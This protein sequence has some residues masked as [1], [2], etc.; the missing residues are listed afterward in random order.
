M[1]VWCQSHHSRLP[2]KL[3]RTTSGSQFVSPPVAQSSL[4]SRNKEP[5][6][7]GRSPLSTGVVV[8]DTSRRSLVRLPFRQNIALLLFVMTVFHQVKSRPFGVGFLKA[9]GG[10]A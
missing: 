9:V 8:L 7:P 3:V 1:P 5:L 2:V 6:E 4:L 10:L